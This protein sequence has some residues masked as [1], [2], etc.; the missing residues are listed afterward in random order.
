MNIVEKSPAISVRSGPQLHEDF[1]S[2]LAHKSL[3]VFVML[4]EI[5]EDKKITLKPN[6]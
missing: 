1:V 5:S 6:R 3:P 2:R 4:P